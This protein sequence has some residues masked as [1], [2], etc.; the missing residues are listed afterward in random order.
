MKIR[1]KVPGIVVAAGGDGRDDDKHTNTQTERI[2]GMGF[3]ILRENTHTGVHSH[4]FLKNL[5]RVIT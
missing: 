4:S 3:M 1:Y 2:S 5:V